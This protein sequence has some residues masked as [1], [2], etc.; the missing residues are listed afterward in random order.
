MSTLGDELGWSTEKRRRRESRAP[1]A[2]SHSTAASR[3]PPTLA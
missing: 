3:D 1:K 2:A